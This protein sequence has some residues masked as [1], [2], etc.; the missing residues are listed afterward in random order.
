MMT[1]QGPITIHATE[2]LTPTDYGVIALRRLVRDGIRAVQEGR[3]PAGV[4]RDPAARIRTR[5][6]NTIL[7]VPLAAT[8]EAD[9]QLLKEIGRTVAEGDYLHRF[10]PAGPEHDACA[11]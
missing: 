7:R 2:N 4:L 8:P 9:E 5:A 1:S 10:S 3:D 11:R 6:Q